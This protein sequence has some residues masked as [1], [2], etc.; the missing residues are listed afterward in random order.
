MYTTIAELGVPVRPPR[1]SWW[2]PARGS[3]PAAAPLRPSNTT[4]WRTRS[5][6]AP[7]AYHS[8]TLPNARCA[9]PPPATCHSHTQRPSRRPPYHLH[10]PSQCTVYLF[11]TLT[12]RLRPLV[13]DHIIRRRWYF[14]ANTNPINKFIRRR[15][16]TPCLL[17]FFLLIHFIHS[18]RFFFVG[19]AADKL[20]PTQWLILYSITEFLIWNYIPLKLK[21]NIFLLFYWK[22][23]IFN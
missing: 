1:D 8:P 7:L 18:I 6:P 23:K 11:R 10:T 17:S 4:R 12:L 13:C 3:R 16:S 15:S 20:K 21:L 5:A 22:Y 19:L 2:A 14:H 9:C